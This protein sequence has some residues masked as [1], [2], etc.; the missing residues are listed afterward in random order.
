MY[1]LERYAED[2]RGFYV[3]LDDLPGPIVR[4]EQELIAA[5]KESGNPSPALAE[6]YRQFN[7]RFNYLDDGFASER[8]LTRIMRN[9]ES[10]AGARAKASR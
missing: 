9:A 7:E 6:R 8:V 5:L 3:N 10:S 1:D 2:I 4:S